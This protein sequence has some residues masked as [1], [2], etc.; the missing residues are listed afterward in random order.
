MINALR[1]RQEPKVEAPQPLRQNYHP[2]VA[3]MFDVVARTTDE[4]DRLVE[5]NA[6]LHEQLHAARREL[7]FLQV[8]LRETEHNR[9]FYQRHYIAL[10]TR[11][12]DMGVMIENAIREAASEAN[13]AGMTP[14]QAKVEV[15]E[16][17][18]EALKPEGEQ[19]A[20]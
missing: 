19:E 2:K 3:E 6:T 13:A 20:T 5:E 7:N 11:L 12:S 8:K 4:R 18:D 9:D 10:H 1:K 14:E 16:A 15:V 17:V